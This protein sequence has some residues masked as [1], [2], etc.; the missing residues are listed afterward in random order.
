M[1]SDDRF[2]GAIWLIRQTPDF[3][4]KPEG[5]QQTRQS[6]GGGRKAVDAG[7][8]MTLEEAHQI[9]NVKEGESMEVI[10]RVR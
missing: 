3:K 6:P 4:Y 2:R 1:S 8:D 7:R 10:R 5:T 9:L